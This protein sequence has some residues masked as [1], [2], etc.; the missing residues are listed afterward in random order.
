VRYSFAHIEPQFT[1]NISKSRLKLLKAVNIWVLFSILSWGVSLVILCILLGKSI[2]VSSVIGVTFACFFLVFDTYAQLSINLSNIKLGVKQ[3]RA[4][5]RFLIAGSM[6]IVSL[7][8]TQ[9]YVMLAFNN[10]NNNVSNIHTSQKELQAARTIADVND[11]K[12]SLAEIVRVIGSQNNIYNDS[13]WPDG[14]F[15][16][17][18]ISSVARKKALLIGNNEYANA[19][20]LQ[21]AV[22]DA[23]SLS[24]S[25]KKLGF[26]VT[27][28]TNGSRQAIEFTF[29]NY[30]EQLQPGDIS[31]FFYSG[32]GFQYKGNNYIVPVDFSSE[33]DDKTIESVSVGR[34][35]EAISRKKVV[36]SIIA[37]DAC[38]KE[39]NITDKEG[40]A[41]IQAGDNTYIALAAAPGKLSYETD[42]YSKKRKKIG[43]QGIFTNSIIDHIEEQNDIDKIF[44][45][46]NIDMGNT[47][48]KIT[49]NETD[50]EIW[51]S[52]NLRGELI[53]S[54]NDVV[55][56]NTAAK[57]AHNPCRAYAA[58]PSNVSTGLYSVCLRAKAIELSQE[59]KIKEG[60]ANQLLSSNK[61]SKIDGNDA[62]RNISLYENTWRNPVKPFFSTAILFIIISSSF[63]LRALM[64]ETQDMYAENLYTDTLHMIRQRSEE[65]LNTSR[66][67]PYAPDDGYLS[68][69]CSGIYFN[70][71]CSPSEQVGSVDGLFDFLKHQKLD[72]QK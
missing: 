43:R 26:D 28:V 8:F 40:L 1:Q 60:Q 2:I 30:L 50:Q 27:L 63:L 9:P 47:I 54:K 38:R 7:I 15:N 72:G 6:S 57:N 64:I 62:E 58:N 23:V 41:P 32:H 65:I 10:T 16:D 39:I 48:K 20:T 22:N 13:S 19:S 14:S 49:G 59:I 52:H 46:A 67:L 68:R 70:S 71:S 12:Y 4:W 33:I 5:R 35:A 25:L 3:A 51:I 44:R 34:I 21:G 36:A 37:I 42:V 45:E 18:S 66:N 29:R 53:L 56:S 17:I 31:F 11:L 61:F 24:Q 69:E 55:N